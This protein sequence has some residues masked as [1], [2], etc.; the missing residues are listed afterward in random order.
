MGKGTGKK[1]QAWYVFQ[2]CVRFGSGIV[3]KAEMA[4][5]NFHSPINLKYDWSLQKVEERWAICFCDFVT[6]LTEGGRFIHR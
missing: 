6:C 3:C 1:K 2:G 5:L 4:T